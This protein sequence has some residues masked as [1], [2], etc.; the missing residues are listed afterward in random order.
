MAQFI[1]HNVSCLCMDFK[2]R[3]EQKD[4]ISFAVCSLFDDEGSF[5]KH[6]AQCPN[7]GNV[8]YV[9]EVGKSV[10][11]GKDEST[12]LPNVEELEMMIPERVARLLKVNRNP[13]YIWQ[14][15]AYIFSYKLFPNILI[16]SHEQKKE[17]E[18]QIPKIVTKMLIVDA[19][20]KFQIVVEESDPLQIA[21]PL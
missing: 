18:N 3:T 11:Q 14:A 21:Q 15:A 9:Q 7:C 12:I 1:L 10:L 6:F 2:E 17:S 4:K 19:E 5:V 13:L 8:H 20:D 16:L